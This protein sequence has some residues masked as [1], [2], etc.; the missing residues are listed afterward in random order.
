MP[1]RRRSQ[2]TLAERLLPW[3]WKAEQLTA[4]VHA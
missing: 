2:T 4:A 3:S 1:E